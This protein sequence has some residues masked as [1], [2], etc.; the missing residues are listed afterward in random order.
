[1]KELLEAFW[2]DFQ[3]EVYKNK[4]FC[5]IPSRKDYLKGTG[6]SVRNVGKILRFWRESKKKKRSWKDDQIY[7]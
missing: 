4:N 5:K 7:R 3:T 2:K 6:Y 1:M